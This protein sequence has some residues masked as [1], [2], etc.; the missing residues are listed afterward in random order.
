MS[1]RELWADEAKNFTPWLAENLP[2]LN[3]A[4]GMELELT[5][6]E[7]QVGDFCCDLLARDL[8]TG[9]SS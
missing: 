3:E 5:S 7:A 1:C 2:L 4:L 9:A 8:G 6:R